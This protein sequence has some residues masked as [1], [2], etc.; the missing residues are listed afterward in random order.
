MLIVKIHQLDTIVIVLYR[1]LDTAA[2]ELKGALDCLDETLSGIEAPLPTIVLCGDL[3]LGSNAVSWILSDDGDLVPIIANHRDGETSRAKQ[4]NMLLDLCQKFGLL[5]QVNSPTRQ[6]S[7]EI[8]DLIFTSDT[9]L[10]SQVEVEHY[11]TFSDHGIITC[12]TTYKNSHQQ[13]EYTRSYLCESGRR[14]CSLDFHQAPW[15]Q[16]RERL[17]KAE[18]ND[19]EKAAKTDID[20]ALNIYHCRVLEIL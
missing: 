14:Y 10:V 4:A 8:L 6:S 15:S 2:S 1:P 12:H 7:G 13:G 9:S 18:W 16:I 19:L 17:A 20:E 11:P 3:N 5:Q